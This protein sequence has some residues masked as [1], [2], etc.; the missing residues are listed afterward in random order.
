MARIVEL[1]E[2]GEAK[3]FV[4]VP[5]SVAPPGRRI[6]RETAGGVLDDTAGDFEGALASIRR[7]ANGFHEAVTDL[8]KAPDAA[9][10][11]FGVKLTAGAGIIIASG[12]AEANVKVTLTW[13]KDTG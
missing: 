4:E 9:V 11:E 6:A 7:V 13:K 3:I 1:N 12:T 10:V 2:E 8:V 5:D